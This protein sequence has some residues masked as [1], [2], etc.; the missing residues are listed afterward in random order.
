MAMRHTP[1]ATL[2]GL[3]ESY[4]WTPNLVGHRHMIY[5]AGFRP[6]ASGGP[7]FMPFGP[8]A[9][10]ERLNWRALRKRA[11]WANWLTWRLGATCAWV[12]ARPDL[13]R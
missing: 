8:A 10:S 2:K 9:R 4:W 1:A 5:V 12:R 6:I 3:E 13:S 11:N 7:V